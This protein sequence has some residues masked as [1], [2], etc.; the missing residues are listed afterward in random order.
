MRQ[1]KKLKC[2]ICQQDFYSKNGRL[3][4][5]FC[6]KACGYLGRKSSKKGKVYPHL[7]RARRGACEVC[8]KEYRAVSDHGTR[9]QR[10]CSKKCFQVY[11]AKAISPTI[12]RPGMKD[13]KNHAWKG[14]EVGYHGI[15]KWIARKLGK[16]MK[17]EM[18]RSEKKKKYE[19]ANIDHKYRRNLKDWIRLCTQCH[20][21]HD[22]ASLFIQGRI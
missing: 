1:K 21:R 3:S 20:R 15:H 2:G 17:C 16:P 14:D 6:S 13:E 12:K 4:Q 10:F 18:C 9:K 5:K 11:W 7:W 22:N 8:E 19:W